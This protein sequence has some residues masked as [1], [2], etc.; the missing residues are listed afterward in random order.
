MRYTL[1]VNDGKSDWVI[2]I[3][4]MSFINSLQKQNYTWGSVK[5]NLLLGPTIL[6]AKI[7]RCVICH[8][9]QMTAKTSLWMS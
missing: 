1:N 2:G 4:V 8:Q 3:P 7:F 5:I 9:K 6:S